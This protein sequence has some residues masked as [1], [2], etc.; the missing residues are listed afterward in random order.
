MAAKGTLL[1][2]AMTAVVGVFAAFAGHLDAAQFDATFAT[3]CGVPG[4]RSGV[5]SRSAAL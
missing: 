4:R 1:R 2:S 3:S 5:V